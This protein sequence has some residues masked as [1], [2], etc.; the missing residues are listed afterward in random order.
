MAEVKPGE[1]VMIIES[2]VRSFGISI[3]TCPQAQLPISRPFFRELTDPS[4]L[5][6]AALHGWSPDVGDE[7]EEL[8]VVFQDCVLYKHQHTSGYVGTKGSGFQP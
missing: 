6:D 3:N 1:S 7:V 4:D 2:L 8:S 5:E